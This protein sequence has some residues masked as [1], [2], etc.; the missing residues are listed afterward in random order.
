MRPRAGAVSAPRVVVD[1]R[2]GAGGVRLLR[3]RAWGGRP[4]RPE[5]PDC[6]VYPMYP[7]YPV[8]PVYED[9]D[10]EDSD[11]IWLSTDLPRAS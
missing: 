8:Y 6:P 7:M 9:D 4:G 11:L 2:A 10:D 3:G 1:P 5:Y